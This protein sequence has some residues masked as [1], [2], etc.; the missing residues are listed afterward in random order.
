MKSGVRKCDGEEEDAGLDEK[1][2]ERPGM[3]H[4]I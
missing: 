1:R 4:I 3:E 2:E